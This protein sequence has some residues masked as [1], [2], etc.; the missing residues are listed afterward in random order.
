M[1]V[2]IGGCG[3]VGALAATELDRQGHSVA[4]IDRESRA[5]RRLPKSYNGHTVV[6]LIFDRQVLEHAGIE[7]ADAFVAVT[8]GDNSNIVAARVAKEVFRVPIVL[9]RIYDPRRAE[10]Y[11]RFGITT[12]T[13]TV[14]GANKVVELVTRPRLASESSFGN[15]EVQMLVVTAADHLMGKAVTMLNVPGEIML[16]V[17][18]RAGQPLI[19]VSGTRFEAG[20]QLHVVVHRSAIEKFQKMMGLES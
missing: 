5:F 15:G 12:F 14:W 2:I 16:A 6:G 10:I 1:H 4:V 7:Q 3:R 8:S 18:V 11:R 9:S 20:D 13:S 19:P 17:V